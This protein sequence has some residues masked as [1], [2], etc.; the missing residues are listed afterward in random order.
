MRLRASSHI[1][2][3]VFGYVCLRKHGVNQRPGRVRHSRHM[4]FLQQ[5]LH[6][7]SATGTVSSKSLW[8]QLAEF[9]GSVMSSIQA[10]KD[11]DATTVA[12]A[13]AVLRQLHGDAIPEPTAARVSRWGSDP[14]SRGEQA[15]ACCTA[16]AW[17]GMKHS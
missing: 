13:M 12:A 9:I 14:Y 10:E 15:T 4:G 11:D 5:V 17:A 1:C 3:P 6:R 7:C 16:E 2:A 8:I